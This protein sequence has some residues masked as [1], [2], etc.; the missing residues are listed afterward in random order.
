MGKR[1]IDMAITLNPEHLPKLDIVALA[2]SGHI[3]R[4]ERDTAEGGV[5]VFLTKEGWDELVLQHRKQSNEPIEQTASHL[6]PALEKI[7]ARILAEAAHAAETQKQEHA[8]LFTLE[9]D[10]FP[11]S[12]QTRLVLVADKTHPVVCALLGTPAQITLLLASHNT[13]MG[14]A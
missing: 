4:A 5:P 10:L 6:L 8:A 13:T 7:S 9:T 12:P 11:S 1:L 2:Q 3:V 14:E